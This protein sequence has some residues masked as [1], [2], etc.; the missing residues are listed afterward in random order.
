MNK[1]QF[2][3]ANDTIHSDGS[4]LS[5]RN[6]LKI[7]GTGLFIFFA[8]GTFGEIALQQR[9][10]GYPSDFNAYLK[11]GEDGR[12]SLFCSKIE[13]GQGII[14][15]MR[16]MLAEE[17]D[18]SLDSI[19]IVMGD[20]ML[21]TWDGGTTGSR[22][23][24]YF[25]PPLRRAGAEARAILLQMASEQLNITPGRLVV[26]D[27]VVSDKMNATRRVTYAELVKGR[28]IDRHLSDVP[29]KSVSEHTVS[30]KPM[31]RMDAMQKTMG[32]AKFTG[33]IKLP[34]MLFAKVLRPPSHDATLVSVDVSKAKNMKGAIVIQEDDLVAVLH[35]KPELAEN[36]LA[37]V[38]AKWDVP[39]QKVDNQSVFDY[40]KKAAP[41]GRIYVE[42]GSIADGH[43]AAKQ[44]VKSEFYNHY[45]AHAP[46]EPY[47]VLADV[48]DER[49][50]VW[51]STQAPFRVQGTVAETL[52]IPEENVHVI[53]PFVG[54][55]FGGKK[56]GLQISEAVK[57][58]KITR[59][60]VQLAWTRKEEFFYD[61]FRPAAM[62]QLKSGLSAAGQITSW[63][64]DIL[65]TGSR[66]S[67]PIYDIPHF[68][69]KTRS[70]NN[71]HPFGTGAWRG[72]GSNTNVFAMESHTDIL[73]HTAGIDPLLF[74]MNNLTDERMIRVLNTV[75]KKFGHNFTKSPSGR[76]Y[77]ISCTNYLNTYVATI[78]HVSVNKSTG[79][80]KVERVVC[81]QD[82][83]EI[84]NP[85]G[86]K[87]Q[88][89]GGI[90]MGLSA[91]LY[92]EIEFS[93][94]KIKTENFDS[95][96]I[97]QFSDATPI[98]VILV[99]NPEIPPQGCGEPAITTVGAALANAIF[100]AVGARVYT[101]PMTPER[102]LAAM[103]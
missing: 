20:T 27:G 95:Y 25:G 68:S 72:P 85:Q 94:G 51:A 91:A 76:G 1:K 30:G 41:D 63:E 62:V 24:K 12:V 101:L 49:A 21:C 37:L 35:E 71:V 55:G 43:A 6:F 57:L 50:T 33:D 67:E 36:A 19:D 84:I 77:G 88:I 22:S 66:S 60:P 45:V 31:M 98:D 78:A 73:A 99:D 75:T 90:T 70:T 17:L 14:T 81:A 54:G 9:G 13:M 56:S 92:E 79:K 87:L 7:A 97:T 102:I 74:R 10:R 83:G 61:A 65:F 69:V 26:K 28:Q 16:Q 40:L 11:I 42:Q 82:M 38:T 46:M 58:S 4:Q 2:S 18:V 47:T 15:S 39:E 96:R 23:T 59:H 100:D 53:T 103:D 64:C 34:G 8:P 5:R 29:I 48:K 89:E 32:E 3:Q 80:V 93:G 86:A 44:T 52:Q